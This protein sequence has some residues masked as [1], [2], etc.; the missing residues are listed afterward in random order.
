[1]PETMTTDERLITWCNESDWFLE[2]RQEEL[3]LEEI[4]LYEMAKFLAFDTRSILIET[5]S[6]LKP[7]PEPAI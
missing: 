2:C 4:R 7:K 5:L 3:L 6:Y 1:M